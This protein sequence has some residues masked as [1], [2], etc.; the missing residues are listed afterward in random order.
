MYFGRGR[1]KIIIKISNKWKYFFPREK[2]LLKYL[3]VIKLIVIKVK[4]FHLSLSLY[5]L[6]AYFYIST[7]CL[8]KYYIITV[9]TLYQ[10]TL[11]PTN[12]FFHKI[13]VPVVFLSHSEQKDSQGRPCSLVRTPMMS[14]QIWDRH[15]QM[16]HVFLLRYLLIDY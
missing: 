2:V 6:L 13:F 11:I 16:P 15:L 4:C 12:I 14:N 7:Y 1:N 10:I 5:S 9:Q 3:R 8:E